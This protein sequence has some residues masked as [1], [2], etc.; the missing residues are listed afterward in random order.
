MG[1]SLCPTVPWVY[2]HAH[3]LVFIVPLLPPVED[4]IKINKVKSPCLSVEST[5]LM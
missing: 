3:V 2:H 4:Q 5:F 1:I